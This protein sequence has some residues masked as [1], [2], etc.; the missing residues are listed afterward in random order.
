MGTAP[1]VPSGLIATAVSGSEINLSW[2]PSVSASGYNVKRST[3][4]NG[5][6]LTVAANLPYLNY[7]DTSLTAGTTYY[8]AVSATNSF[9]PSANS[10]FASAVPV[11]LTPVQLG[12]AISA[13]QIQ[14]TWPQDHTGWTLQVQTNTP[15]AGLGT[16]WITVPTSQATNQIVFPVDSR[17][18]SVFFRLV[19]P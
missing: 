12:F 13:G 17:Q 7:T 9:G 8:Y 5:A 19:S 4:S 6:Y 1:T 11:S 14:M 10:S 18:G 16:N 2:N 15:P 3:A